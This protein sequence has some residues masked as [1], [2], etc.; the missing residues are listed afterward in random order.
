MWIIADQDKV[1][2]LSEAINQQ[3]AYLA[4]LKGCSGILLESAVE[5]LWANMEAIEVALYESIQW[6]AI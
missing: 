1:Q 6:D 2:E 4:H 5:Q 3:W